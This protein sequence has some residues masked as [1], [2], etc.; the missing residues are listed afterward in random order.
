[1]TSISH[2]MSYAERVPGLPQLSG[3]LTQQIPVELV[4]PVYF[5][6]LYTIRCLDFT[7]R[8]GSFQNTFTAEGIVSKEA[9]LLMVISAVAF[10]VLFVPLPVLTP[11][12]KRLLIPNE[13]LS[14]LPLSKDHLLALIKLLMDNPPLY[15]RL[16]QFGLRNDLATGLIPF[17]QS[18]STFLRVINPSLLQRVS[19]KM[20][21]LARDNRV[22]LTFSFAEFSMMV[23]AEKVQSYLDSLELDNPH[24]ELKAF[25]LA[26]KNFLKEMDV[27]TNNLK[28]AIIS[29]WDRKRLRQLDHTREICTVVKQLRFFTSAALILGGSSAK[30]HFG[31]NSLSSSPSFKPLDPYDL[32]PCYFKIDLKKLFS[33]EW[34]SI[35]NLLDMANLEDMFFGI[36]TKLCLEV[37][38]AKEV[39]LGSKRD[40]V[41]SLFKKHGPLGTLEKT[42]PFKPGES[43]IC[44]GLVA[45]IIAQS[46]QQLN[47][48]VLTKVENSWGKI[49]GFT[50][51]PFLSPFPPTAN[52]NKISPAD[53]TS[54]PSVEPVFSHL[55]KL[56]PHLNFL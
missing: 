12:E 15:Q 6:A 42:L 30:R 55:G 3:R 53:L 14:L 1:M 46:I 51:D 52:L 18:L 50:Q 11:E 23:C 43:V 47:Q 54:L 8:E 36:V 41:C 56:A 28:G 44:S 39:R 34:E 37:N 27:N 40:M 16:G 10:Y 4:Y 49:I 25:S 13:D 38:E 31:F 26:S 5:L 17:A 35:L 2:L 32:F 45:K 29:I 21:A 19:L 48:H 9:L 20:E 33:S 24:S 22:N 7:L